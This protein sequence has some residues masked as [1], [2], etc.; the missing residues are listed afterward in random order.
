MA[1]IGR[2]WISVYQRYDTSA[3]IDTDGK[4]EEFSDGPENRAPAV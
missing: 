4:P 2:T 1:R 3:G